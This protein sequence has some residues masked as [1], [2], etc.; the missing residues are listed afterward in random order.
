MDN[1]IVDY[2]IT[3]DELCNHLAQH[4]CLIAGSFALAIFLKSNGIEPKYE[5][6]DIDIW[7]PR[8]VYNWSFERFFRQ[9]GF[10][11]SNKFDLQNTYNHG[12][13]QISTITP[14]LKN[15][16]EI[17]LIYIEGNNPMEHV[18]KTF[19]LTC[20]ISWID[21]VTKEAKNI[22][23]ET[24]LKMETKLQLRNEKTCTRVIKYQRRGFKIIN[25]KKNDRF[26]KILPVY[27]FYCNVRGFDP[28]KEKRYYKPKIMKTHNA[29]ILIKS[30]FRYSQLKPTTVCG[31]NKMF[32]DFMA[33]SM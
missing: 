20:C 15:G 14:F 29:A 9:K 22:N 11:R 7:I 10:R 2:S 16:K 3:K 33:L 1:Y 19:D 17:Q 24:T 12:H 28:D 23:P 32:D 5:P 13:G 25:N 31:S 26:S 4:N 21:N 18:K 30:A 6:N 27:D 8:S